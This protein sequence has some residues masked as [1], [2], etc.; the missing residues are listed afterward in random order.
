MITTDNAGKTWL[1]EG[2]SLKILLTFILFRET[3]YKIQLHCS[4]VAH[5]QADNL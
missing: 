5:V 4:Y 3:K 2:I 1:L